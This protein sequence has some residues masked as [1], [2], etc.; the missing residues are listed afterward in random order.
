M[1]VQSANVL[2]AAGL[3]VF[4][5]NEAEG[6]A[7]AWLELSDGADFGKGVLGLAFWEGCCGLLVG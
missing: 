3:A 7:L 5:A 6:E 1:A 4:E 2:F